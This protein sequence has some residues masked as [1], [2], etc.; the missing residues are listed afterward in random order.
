MT[1]NLRPK[2]LAVTNDLAT[3]RSIADIT[4]PHFE[5][6]RVRDAAMALSLIETDGN[7]SV[8]VSEHLQIAGTDNTLLDLVRIR[9]GHIKRIMLTTYTDLSVIVHGLHTGSIQHVIHKP[10][11]RIELLAVVGYPTPIAPPGV[12]PAATN[13]LVA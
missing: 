5:T 12:L 3:L 2:L 7:I 6:I 10:V 1:S 11:N 9:K 8:M 13:R 4:A